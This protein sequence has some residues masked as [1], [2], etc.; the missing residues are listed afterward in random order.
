M[1][2]IKYNIP[3]IASIALCVIALII[4]A[5]SFPIS[6]DT[7]WHLATGR[8]FLKFGDSP[9][10]DHFTFTYF[11]ENVK[12]SPVIFQIIIAYYTSIFGL[13]NGYFLFKLT[14]YSFFLTAIYFFYKANK[15]HKLAILATLPFIVF[16]LIQ[17]GINVRPE[18]ISYV[19]LIICLTLYFKTIKDFNSKNLALAA[20]LLILWGN[21]HTPVIGYIIIFGLFLEKGICKLK[22]EESFSWGFYSSW[23]F[24]IFLTGF[25]N[26]EFRHFFFSQLSFSTEW[27]FYIAEYQSIS[28]YYSIPFITILFSLSILLFIWLFNTKKYGMLFICILFLSQTW[29][30][31]RL[32]SFT[33]ITIACLYS[34]LLSDYIQSY[35]SSNKVNFGLKAVKQHT[36]TLII[37]IAITGHL[38]LIYKSYRLYQETPNKEIRFPVKTVNYLKQT[39][40]SGNIFNPFPIGGYLSYF[41]PKNFKIYIDGRS[42][43]LYPLEFYKS[44]LHMLHYPL[45]LANEVNKYNINYALLE[46]HPFNY[47]LIFNTNIFSIDYVDQYFFLATTG[48][49]NFPISGKILM[50]PVCWEPEITPD[51]VIEIEKGKQILPA[52]SPL[53]EVL[54]YLEQYSQSSDKRKFFQ[55]LNSHEVSSDYTKRVLIY[56]ALQQGFI[57]ESILLLDSIKKK[58]STDTM[59]IAIAFIKQKKYNNAYQFLQS[60]L[61]PLHSKRKLTSSE[62]QTLLGIMKFLLAKNIDITLGKGVLPE[63][64]SINP[65]ESNSVK[66]ELCKTR[67][68]PIIEDH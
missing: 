3:I 32:L 35:N 45:K 66:K 51:L 36:I 22:G 10:H 58:I 54:E 47:E 13:T 31:V 49:G 15:I 5:N 7:Y 40:D 12:G 6:F 2:H 61:L 19:F 46:N 28:F 65:I 29:Y 16:F 52:S 8:D 68:L 50:Q 21:Y 34:L 30:M 42:N 20:L 33:G 64:M 59:A 11:G 24:I 67:I 37:L 55:D 4:A 53:R 26:A 39:Q 44:Y 1:K 56:L 38:Y 60:N 17:R 62:K 18:I 9:F 41:L 63:F 23:G 57:D 14:V 48:P 25:I 27:R 43:I